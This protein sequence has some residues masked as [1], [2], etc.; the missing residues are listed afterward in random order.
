MKEGIPMRR[1]DRLVPEEKAR[2]IIA[3]AEYGIFMT[4]DADGQPYG[5]AVSHAVEGNKI[6]FHCATKG[7]KLKNLR[8][9]PKACMSFVASAFLDKEAYTHRYE[10]AIAEGTAV[11]VEDQKEKIHA[12]RLICQKYAAGTFKDTE[13]YIQERLDATGVCRMDMET[14]CG[15]VNKK[16]E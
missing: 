1:K 7:R 2:E 6:Y 14:L 11:I 13:E 3:R 9:N 10:S 4:A 15:K 5:V 8:E 12:L 16:P